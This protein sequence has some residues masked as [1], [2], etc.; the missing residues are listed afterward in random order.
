MPP[1]PKGELERLAVRHLAAMRYRLAGATYSVIG[2]SGER[3]RVGRWGCV[4]HN[5]H[6]PLTPPHPCIRG[7]L[8]GSGHASSW[9]HP[10]SMDKA[11]P[12]PKNRLIRYVNN[13]F[14]SR[15][16][17]SSLPRVRDTVACDTPNARATLCLTVARVEPRH[18]E[19][20]P[21]VCPIPSHRCRDEPPARLRH[22]PVVDCPAAVPCPTGDVPGQH[23]HF[24]R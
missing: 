4:K 20:V 13:F 17:L 11:H 12:K 1:R 14:G 23:A 18:D 24:V 10:L 21:V 19:A 3:G 15:R 7:G 2:A 9:P 22:D 8:R 5:G 6:P 16:R